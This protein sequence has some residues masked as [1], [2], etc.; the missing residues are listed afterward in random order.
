MRKTFLLFFAT[1]LS[2]L[3][4][5]VA[6]KWKATAEGPNGK[7]ERTFDFTVEGEKLTGE[8]VSSFAGKSAIID[9]KVKGDD[10]SFKLNVSFGGNEMQMN[11]KGKV[12]SKDEIKFTAEVGENTIEWA[13]QRQ[14]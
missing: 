2:L 6:G 10:L 14:Q 1:A 13:A 5:D 9:G 4:A 8:S 7:M 12:V 11:Y 3:A